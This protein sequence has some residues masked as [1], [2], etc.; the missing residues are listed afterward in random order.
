MK[1]RHNVADGFGAHSSPEALRR[2][3]TKTVLKEVARE[4]TRQVELW[5]VQSL[6]FGTNRE[7]VGV[8]E[9]HKEWNATFAEAGT[10][11]W[12]NVLWE[13]VYEASAEVDSGALR[14][15]LVQI[16]AVAVAAIEDIDRRA[17]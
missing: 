14:A 6:P 7:L 10:I 11:T 1:V 5:G 3:Q 12:M 8:A 9:V 13:E 2:H 15:E 4:R 16:A 17:S